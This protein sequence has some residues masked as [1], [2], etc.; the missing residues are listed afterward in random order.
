M[1]RSEYMARPAAFNAWLSRSSSTM[2]SAVTSSGASERDSKYRLASRPW[3][4]LTWPKPSKMPYWARMRLAATRS[5]MR[6]GSARASCNGD[7]AEAR[8]SAPMTVAVSRRAEPA[9]KC[10]RAIRWSL[11]I[12]RF[13]RGRAMILITDA[14]TGDLFRRENVCSSTRVDDESLRLFAA[15]DL[16]QSVDDFLRGWTQQPIAELVAVCLTRLAST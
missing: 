11:V 9:V 8:L 2:S 4:T 16:V 6:A 5:S 13:L 1:N 15:L 7:C 12:G 3:R 10:R 14:L